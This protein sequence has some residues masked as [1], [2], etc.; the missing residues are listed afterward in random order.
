VIWMVMVIHPIKNKNWFLSFPYLTE[1]IQIKPVNQTLFVLILHDSPPICI[2]S[3][4]AGKY[5]L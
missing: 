3:F 4:E 1:G 5:F 2:Y